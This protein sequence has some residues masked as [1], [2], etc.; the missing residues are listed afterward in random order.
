MIHFLTRD[1]T[2][3]QYSGYH[4]FA[5]FAIAINKIANG[6]KLWDNNVSDTMK[7]LRIYFEDALLIIPSNTQL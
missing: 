7:Q 2:P 4:I 1:K 6:S 5:H 3:T